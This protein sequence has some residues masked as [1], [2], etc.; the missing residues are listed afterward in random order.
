MSSFPIR[1]GLSPH[2]EIVLRGAPD[3]TQPATSFELRLETLDGRLGLEIVVSEGGRLQARSMSRAGVILPFVREHVPPIASDR[4]LVIEITT[5]YDRLVVAIAG[6]SG[7][8]LS[9]GV[10]LQELAR[11]TVTGLADVSFF[12][13][14]DHIYGLDWRRLAKPSGTPSTT[15]PFDANVQLRPGVS[16]IVRARN[17]EDNV[18]GCLRSIAPRVEEVIFCD[19]GSTDRTLAIAQ[20]L[21]STFSNIKVFSYPIKVPRVGKDHAEA[22]L[23]Q[24]RNT[25][26]E[27]YNWCLAKATCYNFTKWDADFLAVDANVAEMYA[28]MDLATRGDNICLYYSGIE[29]YFEAGRWWV[30]TETMQHE[31]RLFSKRHG[32]SWVDIPPW[33]EIDQTYLFTSNKLYFEKPVYLEIFRLERDHFANRGMYLRD[34]RDRARFD[35]VSHYREHG[36]LPDKFVEVSGPDDPMFRTMRLTSK[37]AGMRDRADRIWGSVPRVKVSGKDQVYP[38]ANI[39]Q[40]KLVVMIVA[41][42]KNVDR[43]EKIRASWIGDLERVGITYYFVIGRPGRPAQVVGDI[44]YLDCPDTYEGLPRKTLAIL[45][46]VAGS[47]FDYVLKID[48]DVVLNVDAIWATGFYHHAYFGG[49]MAGQW[50]IQPEWHFGKC[51]DAELN[52]TPYAGE[53]RGAWYAGGCGYFLSRRAA[54]AACEAPD[55][56]E[57][58]LYEDKA[59]GD[60]LRKAGILV[61]DLQATFSCRLASEL[62]AG[63]ALPCGLLCYDVPRDA[64]YVDVLATLKSVAHADAVPP[65]LQRDWRGPVEIVTDW[66]ELDDF[67][68]NELAVAR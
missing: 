21:A 14:F 47:A 45:E 9:C 33:E 52:A 42:A 63:D 56:F 3:A 32:C 17:E 49:V 64:D 44:L 7:L 62:D 59:V 23:A 19:N 57:G 15:S 51:D 50:G 6:R 68:R 41:C 2:D 53:F 39:P 31:Y 38:G 4:P 27:F 58:E 65:A 8:E 46:H 16:F 67:F 13:R 26:A 40:L 29:V 35:N 60:A 12:H 55:I 48:D 61:G 43:I 28:E 30:D 10:P 24:S 36:R 11:C 37:Q 25:L 54:R 34:A 22:V 18:A 5:R 20:D 66:C 1:G